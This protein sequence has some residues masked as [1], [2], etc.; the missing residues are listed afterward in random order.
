M[1]PSAHGAIVVCQDRTA[2]M[3]QIAQFYT[4]ELDRHITTASSQSI[5]I[6]KQEH[7]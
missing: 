5:A 3:Q 7:S 4:E 6:W 2:I 1:H